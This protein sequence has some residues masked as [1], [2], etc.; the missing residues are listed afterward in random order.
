MKERVQQLV[1]GHIAARMWVMTFHSACG[2]ML[3]RDAERLGYRSSFTIYD[4][5]DQMRLVQDV[6][7]GARARSQAVRAARRSTARS[8]RPRTGC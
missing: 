5:A 2:R 1:G 8:P 7:R 6:H 4:Q 3:R